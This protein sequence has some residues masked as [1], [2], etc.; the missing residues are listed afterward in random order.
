MHTRRGPWKARILKKL[1][2]TPPTLRETLPPNAK[3]RRFATALAFCQLLPQRVIDSG[4]AIVNFDIQ[5]M[6]DAAA[7]RIAPAVA[8]RLY[9]NLSVQS[10]SCRAPPGWKF[11]V[12][13]CNAPNY[14]GGSG[15]LLGAS[16][17]AQQQSSPPNS[18]ARRWPHSVGDKVRMP[19][20]T[21]RGATRVWGVT[22]LSPIAGRHVGGH[23]SGGCRSLCTQGSRRLPSWN[24]GRSLSDRR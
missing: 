10:R 17:S 20:A 23:K 19:C 3:R 15:P 21:S 8:A 5:V 18:L 16:F 2:K 6:R 1:R 4:T 13:G 9:A 12:W 11:S 14:P 22:C 24:A 7:V